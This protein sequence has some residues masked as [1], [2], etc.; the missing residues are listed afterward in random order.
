M[1]RKLISPVPSLPDIRLLL[2]FQ[3]VHSYFSTMA[4]FQ[5]YGGGT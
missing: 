2:L 3:E 1:R 5:A 4:R